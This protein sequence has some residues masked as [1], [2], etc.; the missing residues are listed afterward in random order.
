MNI[1]LL[2]HFESIWEDKLNLS[3]TS[4][5]I[6]KL[7]VLNY[8]KKN[9][10]KRVIITKNKDVDF[11]MDYCE[12]HNYCKKNNIKFDIKR[13][14]FGWKK[15]P[16]HIKKEKNLNWCY[17]NRI[18]HTKRDIL[19]IKKWMHELKKSHVFVGGFFKYE[20]VND[21]L[22]IFENINVDYTYVNKLV[23]S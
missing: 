14:S 4:I 9:D 18:Y 22:T 12:I 6:E 16:K 2:H 19:L 23:V 11:E 15:L 13:Y 1:L 17:G 20:C 5:L 7:K 21:I 10:I 3:G 8:L